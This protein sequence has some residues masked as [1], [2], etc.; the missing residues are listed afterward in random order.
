MIE[1]YEFLAGQLARLA[2]RDP[3]YR[4]APAG[5]GGANRPI[6]KRLIAIIENQVI[7]RAPRAALHAMDRATFDS[8]PECDKDGQP[9]A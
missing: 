5:W 2:R 7:V 8:W 9:L 4:L 3:R 1:E 6:V